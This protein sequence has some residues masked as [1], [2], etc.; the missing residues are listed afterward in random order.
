MFR[1]LHPRHK[2]QELASSQEES[3]EFRSLFFADGVPSVLFDLA[4]S[5]ILERPLVP[6]SQDVVFLS[7]SSSCVVHRT[8]KFW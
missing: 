1:G 2:E 7:V 3:Q 8:T 4:F 6:L 5:C